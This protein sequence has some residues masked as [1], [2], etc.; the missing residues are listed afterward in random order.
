LNKE[1][2]MTENVLQTISDDDLE[3]R[4]LCE[5]CAHVGQREASEALHKNQVIKLKRLGHKV[6]I[7]GDQVSKR[8]QWM[9]LSWTESY[10]TKT[11]DPAMP[12]GIKHRCPLAKQETAT[13]IDQEWW[14]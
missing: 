8:G 2:E 14:E 7:K 10:C 4:V 3:D 1:L 11:G 12:K 9:T 6:A 13:Q 5:E